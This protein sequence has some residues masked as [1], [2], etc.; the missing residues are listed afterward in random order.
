MRR[1]EAMS[2]RAGILACISHWFIPGKDPSQRRCTR[3]PPPARTDTEQAQLQAGWMEL[4]ARTLAQIADGS[5][6]GAPCSRYTRLLLEWRGHAAAL[7]SARRGST[8]R[9]LTCAVDGSFDRSKPIGL[10][11]GVSPPAVR[12]VKH[13][14]PGNR[15]R[16]T[17]MTLGGRDAGVAG[18]CR[19]V[20]SDARGVSSC[21]TPASR[22]GMTLTIVT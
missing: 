22:N 1:A 15:V 14:C 21:G 16:P 18:V 4:A 19:T 6:P 20:P 11:Y 7:A 3:G 5:L 8:V 13:A 17:T 9:T 12:G 10:R 2:A